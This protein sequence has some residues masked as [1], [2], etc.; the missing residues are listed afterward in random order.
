MHIAQYI[1]F[2]L[3]GSAFEL[4]SSTT[5]FQK[6]SLDIYELWIEYKI[7]FS[8]SSI[9]VISCSSIDVISSPD[10]IQSDSK[11]TQIDR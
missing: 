11:V 8:P 5:I 6:H 7:G 9:E 4:S 3:C 2:V 1:A 10:N